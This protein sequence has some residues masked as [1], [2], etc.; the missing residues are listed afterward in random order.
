MPIGIASQL[1]GVMTSPTNIPAPTVIKNVSQ[2]FIHSPYTV[3]SSLT[4][5]RILSDSDTPAVLFREAPSCRGGIPVSSSSVWA[6]T[7]VPVADGESMNYNSSI[8]NRKKNFFRSFLERSKNLSF[9]N[10]IEDYRKHIQRLF[11]YSQGHLYKFAK[12]Y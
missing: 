10:A 11:P 3:S 8:F 5:I 4:T 2:Y 1:P 12:R 7:P 6:S 9:I